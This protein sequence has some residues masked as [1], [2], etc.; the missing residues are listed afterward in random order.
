[1]SLT[2]P[3]LQAHFIWYCGVGGVLCL[4]QFSNDPRA[5][6]ASII[7]SRKYSSHRKCGEYGVVSW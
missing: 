3:I 1:M 4:I 6:M 7:C 5:D 2:L